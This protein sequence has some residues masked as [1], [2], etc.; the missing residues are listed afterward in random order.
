MQEKKITG[1]KKKNTFFFDCVLVLVILLVAFSVFLLFK[2]NRTVGTYAEVFID[3]E[4]VA[5]Y[6]LVID[7]EYALNGG[8]NVL[9]IKDGKAY[10]K[11][12][13]CPD[14]TCVTRHKK[15]VSFI[16]ETITC[17]PN[18]VMIEIV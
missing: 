5:R 18:R 8:T 7:G 17:L 6:P 3:D 14:K 12:A 10:M 4:V 1:E 11:E 2:Y 16:G 15:G 13:S 9:V